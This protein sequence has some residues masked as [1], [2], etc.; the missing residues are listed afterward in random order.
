MEHGATETNDM[1]LLFITTKAFA[2][3]YESHAEQPYPMQAVGTDR[4]PEQSTS[5]ITLSQNTAGR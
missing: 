3:C 5:T 4:G 2:I 1:N